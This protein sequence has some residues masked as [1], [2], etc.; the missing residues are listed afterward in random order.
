MN[1]KKTDKSRKQKPFKS[2]PNCLQVTI[3]KGY[4]LSLA[5]Y[6][7]KLINHFK[8][9]TSAN[10]QIYLTSYKRNEMYMRC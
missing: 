4:F 10:Q 8:R 7:K 9:K 2:I 3:E 5:P 1:D 6:F